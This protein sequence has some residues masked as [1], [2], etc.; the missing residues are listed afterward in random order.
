MEDKSIILDNVSK[1]F[2]I[3]F[4]KRHSA[5]SNLISFV[6]GRETKKNID[7][8]K[9][10]SFTIKKGEIVGI[11]GGNGSGKSTLLRVI[12][13]IYKQDSGIVI[14]R[15]KIVSLL[16]LVAGLK[17]K[18]TMC[19]NVYLCS[20]LFGLNQKEIKEKFN[21]I[22]KF[23]ELDNFLDTKIYQFSEGMKQRLSFSV[24]M[25]CNPKILLLDEVFEVGDDSFKQKSAEVIK[26]LALRG[27]SVV[28]VSHEIQMIKKYCDEVIWIEKGEINMKGSPDS[29]VKKYLN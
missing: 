14:T 29:V 1:R 26:K 18:L 19:E 23:S 2:K 20:S 16:N 27:T 13:G 25:H 8:L 15:G 3:G 4:R 5:L 9:N 10:I 24:A 6:S 7:A 22:V 21:S 12:A 17:D 28:L 11:I